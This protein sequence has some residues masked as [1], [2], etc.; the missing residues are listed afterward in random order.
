[1]TNADTVLL[2]GSFDCNDGEHTRLQTLELGTPRRTADTFSG[3]Q[4]D[5]AAVGAIDTSDLVAMRF[6]LLVSDS[7]V[8]GLGDRIAAL[9]AELRD[10]ADIT[11]GLKGSEHTGTIKPR[12]AACPETRMSSPYDGMY[13]NRCAAVVDVGVMRE[14]WVYGPETVL[15]DAYVM[16]IPGVRDLSAMSTLGA[17]PLTLEVE[18]TSADLHQLLAGVY[19]ADSKPKATFIMEGKDQ[20]WT[21]ALSGVVD[22]AAYGN[23]HVAT[24]DSAAGARADFDVSGLA[25]GTYYLIANARVTGGSGTIATPCTETVTVRDTRYRRYALGVVSLPLAKARGAAKSSLRVTIRGDDTY[26]LRFN[27]LEFVPVTAGGM[28]GWHHASPGGA[29][30][31]LRWEDDVLYGDDVASH[32]YSVGGRRLAANHGTLFITGEGTSEAYAVTVKV[33]A[34]Y[35]PRWESFIS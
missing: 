31:K 3:P 7:S 18:A 1:M 22:P 28:V 11:V 23:Y 8:D 30:T 14:P 9:G 15:H 10:L 6:S 19:P 4:Y 32:A 5:I 26:Y 16:T 12:I 29:V 20:T 33:T 2:V 17:A 25:D 21:P 27:T 35:R 13:V 34:S 24:K